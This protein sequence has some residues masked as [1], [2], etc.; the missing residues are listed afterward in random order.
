MSSAYRSTNGGGTWATNATWERFN[1]TSWVGATTTPTSTNAAS[2]TIRAGH[3][4]TVQAN[5][6]ID[7]TYI[8]PGGTLIVNNKTLTLAN[9]G[10]NVKLNVDGILQVDQG[11][12]ISTD[13]TNRLLTILDGGTYRHNY[14]TSAGTVPV[15]TWAAGSTCEIVGYTSNNNSIAGVNQSF[16]NFTWNCTNQGNVSIDMAGA[17]TT[18]N[19]ALTIKSTG[20]GTGELR[21]AT[22]QSTALTIAG[23]Y[24]HT[25]GTFVLTSG[26][27]SPTVTVNGNF[28]MIAGAF[29]MSSGAGTATMQVKGNFSQTTGTITESSSG[30]GAFVF[31]GAGTQAFTSGGTISNSIDFTVNSGSILRL[32]TNVVRGGGN[33]TLSSGAGIILGS[34]NGI[35]STLQ[36]NV[37]V[38]GSRTF[39]PGANYTYV[40]TAAAQS[41]GDQLPTTVNSLTIDNM[42]SEVLLTR[43][44]TV[45][46]A[47]SLVNGGFRVST[48]TLTL[49]GPVTTTNGFLLA[50]SGT[51]NYAQALNGQSVIATQY[52][53]LIFSNFNKTLPQGVEIGI[54]TAFTPGTATGHTIVNSTFN[55]YGTSQ[56]V[57]GFAYNN[58]KLSTSGWKQLTGTASVSGDLTVASNITFSDS[59]YTLTVNG[60]ISNAGAHTGAGRIYLYGG[61]ASHSLTGGGSYTNLEINDGANATISD[62]STI[63]GTF[64]ITRGVVSTPDTIN[65]SSAGQVYRP[66]TGLQR[67]VSGYLKKYIAASGT[68]VTVT[69]EVGSGNDYAPVV[70]TFATVTNAGTIAISTVGQDHSNIGSSG[71]DASR[72]ANRFWNLTAFGISYSSYNATFN[73]Q[74]T[75]LDPT[76]ATAYFFVKRYVSSSWLQGVSTDSSRTATSTRALAVTGV[77]QFV[78]GNIAP[79]IYWTRGNSTPNWSDAANWST[80]SL[81][82]INN[83]VVFQISGAVDVN[84]AAVCRSIRITNSTVALTVKT[85]Y[86]LTV[87]DSIIQNTGVFAIEEGYPT[88]SGG[89]A[90][91]GGTFML[92]GS[93]AQSIRGYNYNNLICA[94]SNTK[95][96][97]A[98]FKVAGDLTINS[99]STFAAASYTDTLYGNWIN[100]GAFT[101]G[102]SAIAMAGSAGTSISGSSPTTFNALTINKTSGS[103]VV[104]VGTSATAATVNMNQGR[105]ETGSNSITVTSSRTGNGYIYGRIIHSHTFTE[106]TAYSFEGPNNLV[107][108]TGLS[109]PT[110]VTEDV[111]LASPGATV[112]L[113]PINRY[114]RLEFTGG[115]A[116]TYAYRFH[117]QS[118]EIAS[119]NTMGSLKLWKENSSGS[120]TWDRRDSVTSADSSSQ[121]YVQL[122]GLTQADTG[123]W[124]LSSRGQAKLVL[125]LAQSK[126]NPAPGDTLTYTIT[127]DNKG[128]GSATNSLLTT[129]IPTNT[130]Y[131]ANSLKYNGTATSTGVTIG[132][133]S[134]TI[135]IN[136]LI[137]NVPIPSS[138]VDPTKGKGTV[139]Y[140]IT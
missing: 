43:S 115:S 69:F 99:G 107:T 18:I 5:V 103:L 97:I 93:G 72:N 80:Y 26:T 66:T 137:G 136:T 28:N 81:P 45:T 9:S 85:G 89:I 29:T 134:I 48:N 70:L 122:G 71:I 51:V 67:H 133:S 34:P 129:Q 87:A 106:G 98:A 100:N 95:T 19:G 44:T 96:A 131:F 112:D 20:S 16:Y 2:I 42:S 23:N 8:E 138:A 139:T 31:N 116:F 105:I 82:T 126:S 14:T 4:V 25:G 11:S 22:T 123:R 118:G 60:N 40:S 76:A 15:A 74:P 83:D 54:R 39:A 6:T 47:L 86:S 7:H 56:N 109:L 41:T 33:F 49:S 52:G 79:I 1:G 50:D 36:G 55:Y 57:A 111:V 128:D 84:T 124:T 46:N 108:F 110:A 90:L 73:F 3:T 75:D 53:T 10:T 38:T 68:P 77:G 94:G 113:D 78:V 119:P 30:R 121:Y 88:V 130:T 135:N 64:S 59:I 63:N 17:T 114:Y 12:S 132:P 27:G 65:I 125:T 101:P 61:S 120:N 37:R 62:N 104:S 32:D 117:Y 13:A 58:L 140:I 127:W 24:V 35:S 91:N 92:S 21:Y 102:T